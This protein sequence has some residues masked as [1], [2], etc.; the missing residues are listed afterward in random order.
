MNPQLQRGLADGSIPARAISATTHIIFSQQQIKEASEQYTATGTWPRNMADIASRSGHSVKFMLQAQAKIHGMSGSIVEPGNYS[1]PTSPN[2]QGVSYNAVVQFGK[3]NRMSEKG[4]I[5]FATMVH[6]ES[7]GDPRNV[8]DGGDSFGL[9]QWN[10]RY[11]PDRVQRLNTFATKVGKP[12][13]D[14]AV[15]LNFALYELKNFYP[16]AWEVLKSR[17]PTTNQLFR[18]TVQYLGF[19][20]RLEAKRKA[21]LEANL[22]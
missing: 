1:L 9:M 4:A 22:R 12:V 8:G 15:Q 5:A 14:P 3:A 17:N 13:T 10:N 18:A 16:S 2:G 11:S 19:D 20:S 21:S 6:D 7:S